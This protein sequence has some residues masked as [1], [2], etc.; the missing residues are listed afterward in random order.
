[1]AQTVQR[2]YVLNAVNC[3]KKELISARTAELR[4]WNNHDYFGNDGHGAYGACAL[5]LC[6]GTMSGEKREFIVEDLGNGEMKEKERIVRCKDCIH[7]NEGCELLDFYCIGMEEMGFCAWGQR[8][9]GEEY[10][11]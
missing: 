6:G 1:M 10:D 8:A 2:S 3:L 7:C 9:W 11:G 4:W 5:G